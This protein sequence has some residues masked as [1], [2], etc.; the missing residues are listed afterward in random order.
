MEEKEYG[1]IKEGKVFRKAFLDYADKEI[2]EV[3]ETEEAAVLYYTERFALAQT[4]VNEVEEKINGTEN[5][6]SY[7]MKVLHLKETLCDFDAIGDFEALYHKLDLLEE[8]LNGFIHQNRLKNLEIK[9]ALLAELEEAVKSSEWKS[10]TAEV[11]EVQRRW[12]K[13]GAVDDAEKE[14]IEGGFKV[15]LDG[16]FERRAAFYADLEKMMKDKESNYQEFIDGAEKLKEIESYTVLVEKIRT[17]KEEW[18][19]LGRIKAEV[20]TEFWNKFQVIIKSALAKAKKEGKA[21]VG[22]KKENLESRTEFL[23]ELIVLNEKIAPV[24]N[25]KELRDKWK[26]LG[27]VSRSEM[28][29]LQGD[30][31][32]LIDQIAEKQF[33]E[34]LMYKK[35]KGKQN[36]ADKERVRLKIAY[37]LLHRDRAELSTFQENLE[38]FNT[39][40]GLDKLIGGKLELQERKVKVKEEILRQFKAG[41]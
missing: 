39:S 12:I 17:L 26:Y 35:L 8:Q 37:D 7:L 33:I 31:L 41:A 13:T 18:K 32:F 16:F 36:E 10:A 14:R 11:K 1:F 6:G 4:K 25:V 23:K 38:K 19:D 21:K 24:A 3:K 34:S 5:K 29:K 27:P 22:N 20:R 2:G 15:M 28:D 30:F 40:S 9:T